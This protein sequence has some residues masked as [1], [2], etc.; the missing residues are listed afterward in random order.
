MTRWSLPCKRHRVVDLGAQH[1]ACGFVNLALL[2]SPCK[3]PGS[4]NRH[5]DPTL[6]L[7]NCCCSR[8]PTTDHVGSSVMIPPAQCHSR[9]RSLRW[10]SANS[11]TS[12][13]D[14]RPRWATHTVAATL[15]AMT[16]RDSQGKQ[17]P[18]QG[19]RREAQVGTGLWPGSWWIGAL[20]LADQAR[21]ASRWLAARRQNRAAH[22][23]FPGHY[24]HQNV[25]LT[26]PPTT[27]ATPGSRQLS[28]L[29]Q[30]SRDLGPAVWAQCARISAKV[31]KGGGM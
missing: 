22:R 28:S 4:V 29:N 15:T 1:A 9:W 31:R 25:S 20:A 6:R 2:Q 16:A 23:W 26:H 21:G 10:T 24:R 12:Q 5:A 3:T 17:D 18:P 7:G 30:R 13:P 8:A 27:N 19:F 14:S 11:Q